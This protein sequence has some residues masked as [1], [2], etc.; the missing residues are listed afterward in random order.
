M[1]PPTSNC[2]Q[3]KPWNISAYLDLIIYQLFCRELECNI[4]QRKFFFYYWQTFTPVCA[5][6]SYKCFYI[7]AAAAA[8]PPPSHSHFDS[9]L[10]DGIHEHDLR[11]NTVLLIVIALCLNRYTTNSGVSGSDCFYVAV[12][13]EGN[14]HMHV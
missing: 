2:F 11:W 7:A 13:P 4:Q 10:A 9:V 3:K 1:R 6:V 14:F 8:P 5:S 12:L